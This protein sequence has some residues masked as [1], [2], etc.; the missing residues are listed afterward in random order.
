[1][2]AP[3]PIITSQRALDDELKRMRAAGQFAFDT[4]FIRDETFDAQLCLIQIAC[5]GRIILVDPIADLDV[6]GFWGLVCDPAVLKVVH[7]GKEDFDV[8][9]RAIGRAPRN[10]FDVQIAAGFVGLGYPLSLARLVM[11]VLHKRL[12]KAQTLTNWSRRP[13]TADQVEYAIDDV[14]HL[15]VIHERLH[16]RIEKL[17]RGAWAA[18]EFGRFEDPGFYKPPVQDRMFRLKGSRSLDSLGLGVLTRLLALREVWARERNRP[19][20]AIVRDDILV[21]IAR[22]RPTRAEQ[23]EVMRGFGLAR[24]TRIV[25]E[26]LEA[27]EV[28]K[29]TP[30]ADL[31][32]PTEMREETPMLRVTLDVLSAFLR[33]TCVQE[34]L[35]VDLVGT[36]Q[37]LRDLIDFAQD[38]KLPAPALCSGWRREFIGTRL[39]DLLEGRCELHLSGFPDKLHLE[40]VTHARSK[41]RKS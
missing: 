24:N 34:E 23:L 36:S 31:P 33:A 40:V 38:R 11:A 15:P 3:A 16:S 5:E 13:L 20:R 2:T 28:A 37:R 25:N 32:Q 27:I 1:M 22:R 8:C 41:S 10:I 7:A 14:A 35:D 17:G 19:M 26:I 6:S 9:L 4:E 21:E 18:E 30:P 12:S 39:L 29:K